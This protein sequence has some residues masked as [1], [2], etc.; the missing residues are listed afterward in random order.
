M[1]E[2]RHESLRHGAV[3]VAY[4]DGSVAG[5]AVWF[6]PGTWSPGDRSVRPPRLS[7]G[8]R[9]SSRHR[10]AVSVRGGPRPPARRAALVPGIIRV[11]PVRQGDG[12][13]AALLRSRLRRC[14]DE[15]LPAY[16]ESS[17]LETVPLYQHF[18]FH[19]TGTLGLPE[20][21]PV[22][23]TMWRPRGANSTTGP[24]IPGRDSHQRKGPRRMRTPGPKT[25]PGG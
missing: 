24:G 10:L 15:G 16:L 3:E 12:V 20:A 5:A 11:D 2:L 19:V 1:T 17:K 6:P 7:A 18:G 9:P 21:A 23:T 22:I 13:G 8:L 25:A 14:D 4:V